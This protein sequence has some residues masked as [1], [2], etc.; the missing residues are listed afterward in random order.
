MVNFK[1]FLDI[2]G[3]PK[4]NYEFSTIKILFNRKVFFFSKFIRR[5]D[6]CVDLSNFNFISFF[7]QD[8]YLENYYL[9]K[10]SK[11]KFFNINFKIL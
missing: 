9:D 5:F 10:I 3:F 11:I 7:Y 4:K 2:N 1:S 8:H 6:V